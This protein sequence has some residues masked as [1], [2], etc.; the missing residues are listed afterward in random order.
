MTMDMNAETIGVSTDE[1]DSMTMDITMGMT[2]TDY[3]K[4]VSIELPA[5][6]VN[7]VETDMYQ[8]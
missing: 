6:A 1:F 2:F 5:D 8:Y 7:A 4:V 3:D